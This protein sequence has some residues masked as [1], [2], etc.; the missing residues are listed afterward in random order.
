MGAQRELMLTVARKLPDLAKIRSHN[1]QLEA[2]NLVRQAFSQNDVDA[3]CMLL[4][5]DWIDF[6]RSS[7]ELLRHATTNDAAECALMLMNHLEENRRERWRTYCAPG[8]P[9]E[10][11]EP[12]EMKRKRE[13]EEIKEKRGRQ[14][15]YEEHIKAREAQCINGAPD[16]RA[17]LTL[18]D[19]AMAR[20]PSPALRCARAFLLQAHRLRKKVPRVGR[21]LLGADG[22]V[23]LA[24]DGQP[25]IPYPPTPS[26]LPKALLASQGARGGFDLSLGAEPVPLQWCNE[27][28][29]AEP[30]AIVFVRQCIDV[31]VRRDWL[32]KPAKSCGRDSAGA[33]RGA[34]GGGGDRCL[35]P[36]FHAGK[37]NGRCE[38]TWACDHAGTCGAQCSNRALQRGAAHRLEVFR[39]TV[40]GWCLRTLT[41]IP[42]GTFVMEY[43]AERVTPARADERT[44]DDPNVET[45]VM[46]LDKHKA[47][48]LDALM[49]RNHAAFAAFACSRKLANM[50][51]E[52]LYTSCWDPS[53]PHVGFFAKRNIEPGEELT[54]LRID[55][56]PKRSNSHRICGC[57]GPKCSGYI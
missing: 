19:E 47:V 10:H 24:R 43:V 45:Y 21:P 8:G 30:P 1:N 27:V 2:Q 57:Q 46:N 26:D 14:K 54:Y 35:K 7:I 41:F 40:K 17:L 56:E 23:L 28:D 39:H 29:D 31:D 33:V 51:K 22:C 13:D 42:Q 37:P 38:C 53:V 3:L 11:K 52:P 49:V 55:A 9:A 50:V 20:E 4:S 44:V 6:E 34:C 48:S 15:I 25:C 18:A 16:S 12:L 32:G 36:E 5:V